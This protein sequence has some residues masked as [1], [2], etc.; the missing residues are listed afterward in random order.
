M[1]TRRI[2]AIDIGSNSI[3]LVVVEAADDSFTV[4]T[5]ER[6]RV[7]LGMCLRRRI[8]SPE[9]VKRSAKAIARFRSVAENHGADVLI[10]VATASVRE[11]SNADYFVREIERLTGVRAEVLSSI[12]EARLIG[13]AAAEFFGMNEG[14][15]L[16]VDI[17][18]GS[19]ELSLMRDGAPEMLFSMK[20]GAVGLRENFLFTNPPGER[21]LHELREEINHAL[22]RPA[23]EL[24]TAAPWRLTTG[25]SGTVLNLASLLDDED[26]EISLGKLTVLNENLARMSHAERAALP[27][28]SASRAEVIVAGGQILEAVMRA[29]RLERLQA[30]RY[31]LREGV[32]I[33]HLRRIEAE[34][35]ARA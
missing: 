4:L 13:I 24:L 12:E 5:Q 1:R 8:I 35:A 7:R 2:A 18:G 10:A 28:I 16:N 23:R 14:G 21:E 25:T 3:K 32:V 19:T 15:L 9:D 6:E 34:S 30:C 31:A 17:G 20:I 27:R 26:G 11:A 33:D 29:L 22:Q